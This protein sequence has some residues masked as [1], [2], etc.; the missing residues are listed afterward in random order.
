VIPTLGR[1]KV[2]ID[3]PELAEEDTEK[4]ESVQVGTL[5]AKFL[6][7]QSLGV[8]P[9]KAMAKAVEDFVD[10]GDRDALAKSV[11]SL[12]FCSRC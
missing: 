4:K 5:V 1:Q 3:Q 2:T 8:L 9:E 7:A 11:H 12:S 6:Q 10:K